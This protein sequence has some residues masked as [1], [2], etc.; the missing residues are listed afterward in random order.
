MMKT[1][2]SYAR[3]SR[4]MTAYAIRIGG[5][6]RFAEAQEMLKIRP[7]DTVSFSVANLI[8]QRQFDRVFQLVTD[9]KDFGVRCT[10]A[11][12]FDTNPTV[13]IFADEPE[14]RAELQAIVDRYSADPRWSKVLDLQ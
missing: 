13:E 9:G 7:I 14:A 2:K 11:R 6:T 10:L 4:D 1:Y 3:A 8:E 5:Q 12:G